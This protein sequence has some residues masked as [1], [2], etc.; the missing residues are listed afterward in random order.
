MANDLRLQVLLQTIDRAAAP[1][2]RIG[3]AGKDTAEALR[4]TRESLR[5]LDAVQ[6]QVGDFRR[7]KQ[8]AR[9]TQAEMAG[10]QARIDALAGKIRANDG[11]LTKHT[12]ELKRATRA[13]AALKDKHRQQT[14]QLQALRVRLAAAG[15][16][17]RQ[18]GQAERRLREDTAA[19]TQR[20]QQ[21]TA[22]LKQHSQ[23]AQRLAALHAATANARAQ[24]AAL[25]GQLLAGAATA[26]G[27]G[28]ALGRVMSAGS[29]F[30]YQLQ[31][32]GNTADM[33]GAQLEDL[34]QRIMEASRSTGQSASNIE[35]ALGFLIAAGQ[36]TD[37][38]ARSIATIGRTATAAGADIEDVSRAAFTLTDTLAIRPEGLQKAMDMLAQAGK[39]GNV[40]LRDMAQVLPLFGSAFKAMKMEGPKAVAT[41]GAALEIA[42]KG[43]PDASIAANNMANFFQKILSPETLKK[44]QAGFGVDLYRVITRAQATGGNPFE[45]AMRSIMTMTGGDQKKLGELFQDAQVQAFVRP[46]LQNWDEYIRIR[47]KALAAEGVTDRDFA[48]VMATTRQQME[49]AKAAGERLAIVFGRTLAPSLGRLAQALAAGLDRVATF[50]RMHPVLVSALV[51]TAAAVVTLRLAVLAL[52]Y[53]W[54]FLGG[55]AL[56]RLAA[57]ARQVFPAVTTGARAALLAVTGLSWPIMAAGAALAAVAMLVWKYWQPL[58]AFFVGVGRGI[59]EVAG[60]ALHAL[61]AALAPLQPLWRALASALGAAGRWLG[62]LFAPLQ[63]TQAQLE[64]ATAVGVRFG[65]VLGYALSG[66]VRA[67]TW[68]GQAFAW[69]GTRIGEGLGGVVVHAGT[70][71]DALKAPFATAF[72]WVAGKIRWLVERWRT[73]RRALGLDEGAADTGAYL[74]A[75]ERLK[76]QMEALTQRYSALRAG[77]LGQGA[78]LQVLA[79]DAIRFDSAP[80]K[81]APTSVSTSNTYHITVPAAPGG[82]AHDTARAVRE[83]LDRRDRAAAA[84]RRSALADID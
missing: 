82:N 13:A 16:D 22:T 55:G 57:S 68:V 40:E 76:P 34:R 14:D 47:D 29:A 50:V 70:L 36:D 84:R 45:A 54:T 6:G 33:S 78:A 17:T 60:P 75:A 2:R 11:D 35:R 51:R 12:S 79:G 66:V 81:V 43:A 64:G 23:Q 73:M 56:A 24:R 74:D 48:R 5:A 71:G 30:D 3:G 21:Q 77:G 44:A 53:A 37:T 1:L 62:A 18:L 39:E 42:R 15:V 9:A 61:G 27:L 46:M 28:Y 26:G 63:A 72:A 25:G 4:Q 32:I 67:V 41:L 7:L 38:A 19:A 49:V 58:G 52:R 31:L 80:V 69:L 20:L 10:L 59:A 83:E 8:G 65:R